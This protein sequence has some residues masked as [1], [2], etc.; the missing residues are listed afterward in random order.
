MLIQNDNIGLKW[1]FIKIGIYY[2]WIEPLIK[3][4][5]QVSPNGLS[6]HL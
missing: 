1:R 4:G 3:K 6:N 2:S 5:H